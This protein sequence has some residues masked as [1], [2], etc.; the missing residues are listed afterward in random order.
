MRFSVCALLAFVAL[1][2]ASVHAT[3]GFNTALSGAIA[4]CQF[5]GTS[6]AAGITGTVTFT[7]L[8]VDNGVRVTIEAQ[9]LPRDSNNSVAIH[10]HQYG[11]LSSFD[12][13]SAGPHFSPDP[14]SVHSCPESPNAANRSVGD[15]GNWDVTGAFGGV[16]SISQTKTLDLI[17]LG[18]DANGIIGRSVVIHE[19][20]DS[21]DGVSGNSGARMAVCVIGLSQD[22]NLGS[23][24]R[25]PAGEAKLYARLRGTSNCVGCAG[26]AFLEDLGNNTLQLT[27]RVTEYGQF[28]RVGNDT[29]IN[30][31]H[32]HQFGDLTSADATSAGPHF[33]EVNSD[34]PDIS[35]GLPPVFN[36]HAGDWGNIQGEWYQYIDEF[37][38]ATIQ[39]FIG[40][41]MIIHSD[42]DKGRGEE[43]GQTGGA[44]ERI[45]AGVLGIQNPGTPLQEPAPGDIVSSAF[46]PNLPCIVSEISDDT[47]GH[48]GLTAGLIVAGILAFILVMGVVIALVVLTSVLSSKGESN[49]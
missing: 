1:L 8:G 31:L 25:G 49:N 40:R 16:R 33:I 38:R 13:S 30:G 28:E 26:I 35:H 48:P 10:V 44:G 21:C 6:F 24:V 37:P 47:K 46:W 22:T 45:M 2:V 27:V 12:G 11:D 36:R 32:T 19:L 9:N 41:A 29:T 15:M 5:S 42:Q 18:D 3:S 7:S 20:T 39:D 4:T 23:G 43:C 14:T 34:I 17:S